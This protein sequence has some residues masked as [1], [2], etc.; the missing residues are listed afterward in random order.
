MKIKSIIISSLCLVL[1]G[2]S[3]AQNVRIDRSDV[4]YPGASY[5]Y[6]Y[7]SLYQVPAD[8]SSSGIN[9]RWDF[10]NAVI[11]DEYRVNYLAPSEENRGTELEG[12]N[13]VIQ[14]DDR[15]QEFAPCIID[16]NEKRVA[17][18]IS[19]DLGSEQGFQPRM[20]VFPMMYGTQW[21]DTFQTALI[22]P[23]KFPGIDS[24]KVE[25]QMYIDNL[26]DA[27]G[28]L[29]TPQDSAEALRV[30][31]TVDFQYFISMYVDGLGWIPGEEETGS[32][33]VYGFYSRQGGHY[34]AFL[35]EAENNVFELSYKKGSLTGIKKQTSNAANCLIYPNPATEFLVIQNQ[36]NAVLNVMDIQGKLVRSGVDLLEGTNRI[37]ISDLIPGQ[38][39]ITIQHQDGTIQ[40]EKLL[41]K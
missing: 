15:E 20:L 34:A 12:C 40:T 11:H 23:G 18:I 5:S 24:I 31:T 25:V 16:D 10:R 33:I 28:V 3:T 2:L 35:E 19:S 29:L 41:V 9:K 7:D 6:Y 37:D 4:G 1:S 26:V 38:Y 8:F 13:L 32:M 27:E 36:T 14:E 22:S 39:F 21:N 17:R 30:R